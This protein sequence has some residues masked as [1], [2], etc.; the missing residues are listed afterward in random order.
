VHGHAG[1]DA[2]TRLEHR[3]PRGSHA[4]IVNTT[5]DVG[6]HRRRDRH[7]LPPGRRRRIRLRLPR[8]RGPQHLR[9]ALQAGQGQARAGTPRAGRGPC[10]RWLLAIVA[11][12]RRLPRDVRTGCHERGHRHR[13]G[14]H[15]L[16][17]DG[18]PD[19]AGADARDRPGRVPGMRHGRH[20]AAVREAQLPRQGRRHRPSTRTRRASCCGRTTP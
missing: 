10:G 17:P 9:R 11:K 5:G 13:H 6:D 7:P 19:R 16:N 2:L 4:A 1:A 15:G 3:E 18:H 12:G 20:H 14:V 8:G